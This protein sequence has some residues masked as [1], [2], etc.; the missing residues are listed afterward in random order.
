MARRVLFDYKPC[1]PEMWLN[2]QG[3][4]AQWV[5]RKRDRLLGAAKILAKLKAEDEA[6]IEELLADAQRNARPIAGLGPPG[7]GKTTVVGSCVDK[8]LSDG[9][10][11]L[12]ALP[13]AQQAA[14]VRARHPEADVDTCAAAFYLWKQNADEHMDVLER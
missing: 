2:R 3:E 9:G 11:V 5:R 8:V 10:R 7:T 6:E 14:R 12:Y 4:I 13:T 1:E